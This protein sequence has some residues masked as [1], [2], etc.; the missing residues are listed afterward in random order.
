MENKK[1][2]AVF[3]VSLSHEKGWLSSLSLS[4]DTLQP[5]HTNKY[6]HIQVYANIYSLIQTDT[7]IYIH[8]Q[9]DTI[10]FRY[11]QAHAHKDIH[12]QA[13]TT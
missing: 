12:I 8:M 11:I 10:L 13:D 9:A 5:V 7:G 3:A 2:I 1:S 6:S 4:M